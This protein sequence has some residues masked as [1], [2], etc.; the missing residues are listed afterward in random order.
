[1]TLATTDILVPFGD[2]H[3]GYKTVNLE[4]IKRV[5]AYIEEH[6]CLWFGMGDIIDNT[7]PRNKFYD[8]TTVTMTA[9]EQ[10]FKFVDL[11]EPIKDK[12]IGLLTGNHEIRSKKDGVDAIAQIERMINLPK[13]YRN[14]GTQTYFSIKNTEGKKINFFA[15]HGHGTCTV[16]TTLIRKLLKMH[17]LA[18]ADVYLMGHHHSLYYTNRLYV[19]GKRSF[20]E[21][22]YVSTGAYLGYWGGYPEQN[23]YFPLGTGCN[24]VYL[25]PIEVRRVS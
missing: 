6:D 20:T 17:E 10:V 24:V 23:G 15:T 19:T 12:C 14:L 1:M 3:L 21:R 7:S 18:E 9:Q 13:K 4:V 16:A 2:L 25:N 11:V 8:Q 22:W 5:I